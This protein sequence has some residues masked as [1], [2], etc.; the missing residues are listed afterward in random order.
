MTKK[1]YWNKKGSYTLEASLLM[2]III[3]LLTAV[4]YL[5]F[6]LHD[7]AYLQNAAY[8]TAL[9]GILNKNEENMLS[10]VE[11]KKEQVLDGR[12]MGTKAV[13]GTV[14]VHDQEIQV[15]FQ[16]IFSFPGMVDLFFDKQKLEID[17]GVCLSLQDPKRTVNKIRGVSNLIMER[18]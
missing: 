3:T 11:K 1:L 17:K 18:R 9:I 13:R 7:Q 2:V 8:E 10:V 14:E 15:Q 12:L 6:F 16:G 5:G 4:I